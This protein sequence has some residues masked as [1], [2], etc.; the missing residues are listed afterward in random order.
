MRCQSCRRAAVTRRWHAEVCSA[1][2]L[3]GYYYLGIATHFVAIRLHLNHGW[4]GRMCL[5]AV[6]HGALVPP[7]NRDLPPAH[8]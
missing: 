8:H 2:M 4:R 7:S 6:A 3:Q 1:S 5:F